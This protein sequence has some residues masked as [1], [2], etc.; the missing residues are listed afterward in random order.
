MTC[1][2]AEPCMK[3][4]ITNSPK[5]KEGQGYGQTVIEEGGFP[6]LKGKKL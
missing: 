6:A 5:W 3:G 1:E 4:L 2:G